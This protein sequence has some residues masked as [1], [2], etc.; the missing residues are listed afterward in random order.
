MISDVFNYN[1][2]RI[3]ATFGV[4]QYQNAIYRGELNYIS[5]RE[6][7]GVM[8]YDTGRIYEG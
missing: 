1:D 7:Y 8:I 3:S 6:G 2:I 4:K 5:E